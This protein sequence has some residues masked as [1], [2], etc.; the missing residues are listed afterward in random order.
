M[1]AWRSVAEAMVWSQAAILDSIRSEAEQ[2]INRMA[3]RILDVREARLELRN[4]LLGA[5]IF[6]TELEALALVLDVNGWLQREHQLYA[7]RQ[8]QW[9]EAVLDAF[10]AL[11]LYELQKKKFPRDWEKDWQNAGGL[12]FDGRFI[13]RKDDPVWTSLSDFCFPF[14][15]FS[16]DMA[17]WTQ[18]ISRKE[19]ER[20]GVL[21][22]D[23]LIRLE[24]LTKRFEPIFKF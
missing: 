18:N 4:V 3:G 14:Q 24:P 12:L 1:K 16:V 19:A 11:E 23:D 17:F 21:T 2:M 7:E 22:A 10:P 6:T 9:D 15:P 8:Q 13:A 5:K 20:L